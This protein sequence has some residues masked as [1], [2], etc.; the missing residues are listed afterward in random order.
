MLYRMT[1]ITQQCLITEAVSYRYQFHFHGCEASVKRTIADYGK[2]RS[3][4]VFWRL[5]GDR[6]DAEDDRGGVVR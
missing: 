3:F 1:V 5:V 6:K 2:H 4:V